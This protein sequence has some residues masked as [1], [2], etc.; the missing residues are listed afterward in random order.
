MRRSTLL[1]AL[2]CCIG[3]AQA[4][5]LLAIG[6]VLLGTLWLLLFSYRHVPYDPSLWLTFTPTALL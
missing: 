3:L 2:S 5:N 1:F 4:A 6:A